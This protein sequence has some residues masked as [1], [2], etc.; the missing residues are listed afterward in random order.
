MAK[1]ISFFAGHKITFP[2]AFECRQT[3]RGKAMFSFDHL[4]EF[5][6]MEIA[7][8]EKFENL[9]ESLTQIKVYAVKGD[10]SH[11][12]PMFP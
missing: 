1:Q 7:C 2:D 5:F 12:L 11:K 10:T 8:Q 4:S 6:Y 9:G 3:V